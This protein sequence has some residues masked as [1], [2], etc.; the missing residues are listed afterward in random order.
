LSIFQQLI[1]VEFAQ[2]VVVEFIVLFE[3]AQL[4]FVVEFA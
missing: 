4:V 1:V 2:L 3:S